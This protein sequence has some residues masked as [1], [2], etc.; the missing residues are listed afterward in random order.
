MN[1]GS[2]SLKFSKLKSNLIKILSLALGIGILFYVINDFGGLE[3]IVFYLKKT[4]WG[5]LVVV[6]NSFIALLFFTAGWRQFLP[7]SDHPMSYLSLLKVRLCGEGIN[8]MTP[9]GF[10]AGDPIRMVLLQK[11]LGPNSQMRS[12]AADRVMHT[13]A[14]HVINLIGLILLITGR[15][16]IP[17]IYSWSLIIFYAVTTVIIARFTVDLLTGRGLGVLDSIL[18]RLRF[19]KRFPKANQRLDALKEELTYYK[20]K[21]KWPFWKSFILH[22][23]GRGFGIVEIAI[24]VWCLEGQFAWQFSYMLTA[25]GSFVM[26]ACG[27]IP[28]ALGPMESL[29]ANFAIANGFEPQIGIAIQMIRRL[30]TFFW[31]AVGIYLLDY[32]HVSQKFVKGRL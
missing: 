19:A 26:V 5:Y 32:K 18:L 21:P 10:I 22:F 27:F 12:V 9:A 13:L 28:G 2:L 30:R 6:L 8:F 20:D 31:I 16:D 7:K 29:S 11:Y 23:I 17:A 3:K 1:S 24:I 4:G 14:A 25:L 15:I